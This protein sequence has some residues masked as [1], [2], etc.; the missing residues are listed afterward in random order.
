MTIAQNR[1]AASRAIVANCLRLRYGRAVDRRS[2]I[3]GTT[4]RAHPVSALILAAVLGLAASA[5]ARGG[6]T[7]VTSDGMTLVIPAGSPVR[8]ASSGKDEVLGRFTGRFT[9]TGLYSIECSIDFDGACSRDG[10]EVFI[11]PDAALLA[12]LPRWAMYKGNK[13]LIELTEA[14]PFIKAQI[15]APTLAAFE[16]GRI[17]QKTGYASIVVENLVTGVDCD[18][19]WYSARLVSFAPVTRI[20]AREPDGNRGCA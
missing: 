15:D 9:I 12:R 18:S 6:D 20:A 4:M 8:L 17:E 3:G 13:P 2:F 1:A 11:Q 14:D 16:A 19:P 10:L 5:D 7:R